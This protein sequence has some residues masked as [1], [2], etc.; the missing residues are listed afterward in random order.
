MKTLISREELAER[1]GVSTQS[2][3]NYEKD[4]VITRNPNI[5]APRYSLD[6][7]CRLEGTELNAMSPLERRR[8]ENLIKKQEDEIAALKKVLTKFTTLGAESMNLLIG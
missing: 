3:I 5:P 8:L 1:W 4:G 7:I 6:E 2:V